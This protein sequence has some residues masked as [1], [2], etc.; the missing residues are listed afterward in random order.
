MRLSLDGRFL[1]CNNWHTNILVF[2]AGTGR[3]LAKPVTDH[4]L[5]AG[6]EN[7]KIM[8]AE[9]LP[10]SHRLLVGTTKSGAIWDWRAGLRNGLFGS[11]CRERPAVFP[12]TNA[13]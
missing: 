13:G 4:P 2:E 5:P 8:H 1:A 11:R 7:Q 9:F 12:G 10:S 6:L 3:L